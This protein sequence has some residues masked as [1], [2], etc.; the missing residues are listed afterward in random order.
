[1]SLN[2]ALHVTLPRASYPTLLWV[3]NGHTNI[4]YTEALL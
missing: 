4:V 3:H 2:V 1:M